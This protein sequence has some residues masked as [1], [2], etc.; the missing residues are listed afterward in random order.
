MDAFDELLDL[1]LWIW[2]PTSRAGSASAIPSVRRAVYESAPG[3]W[4]LGAH[5][6]CVGVSWPLA[7][8]PAL[9]GPVTSST[10]P[11]R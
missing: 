10:G 6:R 3:G 2:R 9:G 5:E 11:A 4:R 8:A 1:G 7:A